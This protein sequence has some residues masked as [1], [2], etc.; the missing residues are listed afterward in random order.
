MGQ[1]EAG[2]HETLLICRTV[3]IYFGSA[4]SMH[5]R[6]T[7]IVGRFTLGTASSRHPRNTLIVGRFTLGTAWTCWSMHLRNTLIVGPF[8]LG[9]LGVCI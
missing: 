5:L 3:T 2:I 8:T 6:H 4:W 1:L 7:L 9:L